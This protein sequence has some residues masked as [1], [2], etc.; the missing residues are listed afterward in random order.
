MS[1]DDLRAAEQDRLE[2]VVEKELDRSAAFDAW[3]RW[4]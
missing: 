1:E 3:R 4:P 2:T